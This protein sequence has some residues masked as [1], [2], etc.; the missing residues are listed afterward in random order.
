MGRKKLS[1]PYIFLFE[2]QIRKEARIYKIKELIQLFIRILTILLLVIFLAHPVIGTKKN[3]KFNVFIYIDNTHSLLYIDRNLN[4]LNELKNQFQRFINTYP[5][6]TVFS[7]ITS[8]GRAVK[9]LYKDEM[10]LR[11][12]NLKT[13][14]SRVIP[15]NAIEM[16]QNPTSSANNTNE[17]AIF[18]DF[19][20]NRYRNIVLKRHI[21]LFQIGSQE[22]RNAGIVNVN[23]FKRIYFLG[24]KI[25]ISFAIQNFSN[26]SEN[27]SIVLTNS[28]N[29]LYEKNY[30]ITK[31]GK[32]TSE[33]QIELKQPINQFRLKCTSD[34]FP[35]DDIYSF[36]IKAWE[37]FKILIA[38]AGE[39]E[40]KLLSESIFPK[41]LIDK[42]KILFDY[43]P[44]QNHYNMVI[45]FGFKAE[46]PQADVIV[47][48]PETNNSI[49]SINNF[50]R[51]YTD[52][53]KVIEMHRD[54]QKVQNDFRFP[55]P[56]DLSG[57]HFNNRYIF[58]TVSQGFFPISSGYFIYTTGNL[59][60]FSSDIGVKNS[61]FLFSAK[62]PVL[63]NYL[64]YDI[65]SNTIKIENNKRYWEN[66]ENDIMS[67]KNRFSEI[68][69]KSVN[70]TESS[71]MR[72]FLLILIMILIL[73]DY[74]V[75]I[76]RDNVKTD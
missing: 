9:N 7:Y 15:V 3:E 38:N 73:N 24:E 60:V 62:L 31:R 52:S 10:L 26:I 42:Q 50:L 57:I 49:T 18:S 34:N 68:T 25:N 53:L 12:R 17:F 29:V 59:I 21:R 5:D 14:S 58:E 51:K 54:I 2:N 66:G 20:E 74:L 30:S 11:V 44:L 67:L 65:L 41:Y 6:N 76:R 19:R 45:S 55:L 56:L 43:K 8:D 37:K 35:Y 22:R 13:V 36:E 32:I 1:F 61:N 27:V 46:I 4:L 63:L 48:I 70:S 28:G 47:L 69:K 71:F 23:I 39:I 33:I 75:S 40:K 64:L 16:L 72:W